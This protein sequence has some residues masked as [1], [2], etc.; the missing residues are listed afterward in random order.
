MKSQE[1]NS[2]SPNQLTDFSVNQSS[3]SSFPERPRE[4]SSLV[5]RHIRKALTLFGLGVAVAAVLL[6]WKAAPRAA[7]SAAASS[8][9]IPVQT[10]RAV[11]AGIGNPAQG[12]R[13]APVSTFTGTGTLRAKREA[14]LAFPVGGVVSRIDVADGA[15][16]LPGAPLATLDPIPFRAAVDQL[17]SRLEFLTGRLHRSEA[18]Y[19]ARAVTSE[20]LDADRAEVAA[21]TAQLTTARWSLEHAVLRAPFAGKVTGRQVELGQV[22]AAGKTAFTLLGVDTLQVEVGI[23]ASE[24]DG[25]SL[26]GPVQVRLSESSGIAA[27][28]RL[29]HA[30]VAGDPRS[31]AIA[32]TVNVPDP[33]GRLL[34]GMLVDCVFAGDSPVPT[35]RDAFPAAQDVIPGAADVGS[36]G[37]GAV[38]VPLSALRVT[39]DGPVV[40]RIENGR[41]QARPVRTGALRRD[42]VLVLSG[43]SPGDL[44]VNEP[45]DRLRSGD[46]VHIVDGHETAAGTGNSGSLA[47]VVSKPDGR[48]VRP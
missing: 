31:G 44:L 19:K 30:P 3:R 25:L 45:P 37:P 36:P 27:V 38:F 40:L 32:V 17:A 28:G 20:E 24:L 18:L 29:D 16:V 5:R 22:A 4:W 2:P 41:A 10:A 1:R 43:L 13:H 12:V 15:S 46:P 26:H 35:A 47:T 33:E 42:P 39:A 34:P 8:P 9:G 14:T 11:A 48:S 23:P 21:V 6:Y 7:G